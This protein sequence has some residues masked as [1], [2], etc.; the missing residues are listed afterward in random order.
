MLK[1]NIRDLAPAFA[2]LVIL[3]ASIALS[4]TPLRRFSAQNPHKVITR[5]ELAQPDRE[6]VVITDVRAGTSSIELN[7]PFDAG[8]EWIKDI[9][10]KITN[11]ST[12]TI[13]FVDVD[14]KFSDTSSSDPAMVRPL[15]FGVWPNHPTPKDVPISLKPGESIDISMPAK[16]QSLKRFLETRGPVTRINKVM[17]MVFVVFFDDGTKWDLGNFYIPDSSRPT[18]FRMVEAPPGI[19]RR[20]ERSNRL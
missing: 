2:G 11:Q 8:G 12:K 1:R 16:Y 15:I 18:G 10:F 6:P 20:N 7:R 4:N 19:I 9:S 3:V 5:P 13:T 14:L 17:I